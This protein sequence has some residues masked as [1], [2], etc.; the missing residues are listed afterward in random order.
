MRG[1][2]RWGVCSGGHLSDASV[3]DAIDHVPFDTEISEFFL[4]TPVT[5]HAGRRKVT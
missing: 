5:W 3:R 1:V 4:T 2:V